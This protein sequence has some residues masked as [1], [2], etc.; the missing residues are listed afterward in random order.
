MATAVQTSKPTMTLPWS[1]APSFALNLYASSCLGLSSVHVLCASI[2]TRHWCFLAAK[3]SHATGVRETHWSL[4]TIN[5]NS[6]HVSHKEAKARD[7]ELLHVVA[8]DINYFVLSFATAERL[9]SFPVDPRDAHLRKRNTLL[10]SALCCTQH[11]IDLEPMSVVTH[12]SR[13]YQNRLRT[14]AWM[15]EARRQPHHHFGPLLLIPV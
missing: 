15:P 9:Y 14:G 8:I 4:Y 1:S 11:W 7:E 5:D 13:C 2:D 12:V 10:H 3:Y 6:S